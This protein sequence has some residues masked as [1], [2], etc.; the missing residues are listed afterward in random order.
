[1]LRGEVGE[2]F[3]AAERRDDAVAFG[4]GEA[5]RLEAE[6]RGGTG[7]CGTCLVYTRSKCMEESRRTEPDARR[8]G[9]P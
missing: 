6:A 3:G 1:M 7:D 9:E 2:D 4:E 8:H 5:G